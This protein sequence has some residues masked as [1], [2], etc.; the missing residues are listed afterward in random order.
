MID[1]IAA[2]NKPFVICSDSHNVETVGFNLELEREKLEKKG[3]KYLTS[4][5][6]LIK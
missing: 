3:Y 4:I 6:D 5:K 2:A 1:I